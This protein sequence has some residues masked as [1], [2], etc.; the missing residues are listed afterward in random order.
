MK[1]MSFLLLLVLI[2]LSSCFFSY[3][4][5]KYTKCFFLGEESFYMEGSKYIYDSY[6]EIDSF[7]IGFYCY[8]SFTSYVKQGKI[9]TN[10]NS[11]NK[12]QIMIE[13]TNFEVFDEDDLFEENILKSSIGWLSFPKDFPVYIL[14]FSINITT[15]INTTGKRNIGYKLF[16]KDY[17]YVYI[18]VAKPID[19]T[20][21]YEVEY[22]QNF[23]TETDVHHQEL[24]FSKS[25]W[26][27]VVYSRKSNKKIENDPIFSS[28]KDTIL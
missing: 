12:F 6:Y 2:L 3:R 7:D 18:Y 13:I 8:N 25:G 16:Y 10:N 23:N 11:N 27:K 28:G 14:N 9:T 1:R 22:P 20:G 19:L 24:N 26:Y 15:N 17:E 21:I 4:H 5:D